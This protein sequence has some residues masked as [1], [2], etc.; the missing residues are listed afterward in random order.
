LL[1]GFEGA[2]GFAAEGG[3]VDHEFSL[4]G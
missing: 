4:A 1:E 2:V 3:F